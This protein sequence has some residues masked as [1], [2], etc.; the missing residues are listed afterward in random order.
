MMRLLPLLLGLALAAGL[1]SSAAAAAQN[2]AAPGFSEAEKRVIREFFAGLP[3]AIPESGDAQ[4]NGDAG[5]HKKGKNKAK[6]KGK[7]KQI[8]PGLAKKEE[9]P[10]GLAQHLERHGNLPPGLAKRNLPDD[11]EARLPPTGPGQARV[12]VDNDVVLVVRTTGRILDILKDI[13]PPR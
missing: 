11:L 12:I 8:P 9:L 13:V 6:T 7:S 1:A 10:K 2:P 3:A 4:E 5:A